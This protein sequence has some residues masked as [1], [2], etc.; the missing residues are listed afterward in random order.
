ML[1]KNPAYRQRVRKVLVTSC[2]LIGFFGFFGRSVFLKPAYALLIGIH[3][4]AAARINAVIKFPI[5]ENEI[6]NA[7]WRS[8]CAP[9]VDIKGI[10]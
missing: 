2:F 5:I 6:R 9:T 8:P 4:T 10:Y 3:S 7:A 1:T